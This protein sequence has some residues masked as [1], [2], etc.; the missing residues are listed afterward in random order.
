VV[1]VDGSFKVRPLRRPVKAPVRVFSQPR[2]DA[3][4]DLDAATRHDLD[5][6]VG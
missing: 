5:E 4:D 1:T 2:S 6:R 3:C